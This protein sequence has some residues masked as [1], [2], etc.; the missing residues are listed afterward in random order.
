MMATIGESSCHQAPR[1]ASEEGWLAIYQ[2]DRNT[3]MK[4]EHGNIEYKEKLLTLV[5]MNLTS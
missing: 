3:R 2:A 1:A 4:R 5:S